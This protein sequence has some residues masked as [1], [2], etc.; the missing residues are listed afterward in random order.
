MRELLITLFAKSNLPSPAVN[1]SSNQQL[2]ALHLDDS[3]CKLVNVHKT[4]IGSPIVIF[5]LC[6]P[7][8]GRW[9]K[10]PPLILAKS[11]RSCPRTN[12]NRFLMTKQHG[13]SALR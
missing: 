12:I 7:S 9:K 13:S 6:L 3:S 11:G 1:S 4:D 10:F 8:V 5:T 2:L